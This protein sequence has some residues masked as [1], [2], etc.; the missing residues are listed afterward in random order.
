MIARDVATLPRV[1]T[2]VFAGVSGDR[3]PQK[4]RR[5][6]KG[7]QRKRPFHRQCRAFWPP[8]PPYLYEN[9]LQKP[10]PVAEYRSATAVPRTYAPLTYSQDTIGKHLARAARVAKSSETPINTGNIAGHPTL[11]E[12]GHSA[13]CGQRSDET[14]AISRSSH[15]QARRGAAQFVSV[16]RTGRTAP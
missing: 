1:Q 8:W 6:A 15:L 2:P 9:Y 3:T 5:V 16:S 10:L 13:H 11:S 4:G 12:G 14:H 7:G